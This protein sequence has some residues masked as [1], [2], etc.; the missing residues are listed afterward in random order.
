MDRLTRTVVVPALRIR[1]LFRLINQDPAARSNKN[2]SGVERN[3]D[4]WSCLGIEKLLDASWGL[5]LDS[6]PDPGKRAVS[7]RS[8]KQ[9]AIAG[10]LNWSQAHGSRMQY[11]KQPSPTRISSGYCFFAGSGSE[12]SHRSANTGWIKFILKINTVSGMNTDKSRE[13]SFWTWKGGTDPD[14]LSETKTGSATQTPH[15]T[16]STEWIPV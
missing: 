16:G 10:D 5:W 4:L 13:R 3:S 2:T 9:T 8:P 7:E 12:S 1:F 11:F 15:S 14:L 6:G